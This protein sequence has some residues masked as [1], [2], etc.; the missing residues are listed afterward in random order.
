MTKLVKTETL[1]SSKPDWLD[2][3]IS[4]FREAEALISTAGQK[5]AS[6]HWK[7]SGAE[8]VAVV[9]GACPYLPC[10]L[11]DVLALA[12]HS[13]LLQNIPEVKLFLKEEDQLKDLG[14]LV[15]YT[16]KWLSL[17]TMDMDSIATYFDPTLV[18]KVKRFMSDV[19]TH[20]S[21]IAS[22]SMKAKNCQYGG[23]V[24]ARDWD[25]EIVTH[26]L[27]DSVATKLCCHCHWFQLRLNSSESKPNLNRPLL[28]AVDAWAMTDV[29]WMF[30]G[31]DDVDSDCTTLV[32][33]RQKAF[34]TSI[35]LMAG[36]RTSCHPNLLRCTKPLRTEL[37]PSAYRLSIPSR[38]CI[39][40][41]WIRA[42]GI[43]GCW[44]GSTGCL[45]KI[46]AAAF[47]CISCLHLSLVTGQDV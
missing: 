38:M 39:R 11:Q 47:I 5:W 32:D 8:E 18:N 34:S 15:K 12:K 26:R 28:P 14:W 16:K 37:G 6:Q 33:W 46:Y 20:F 31:A 10:Q 4:V 27:H 23:Q 40:A 35:S 45:Y 24:Q 7:D 3:A 21:D 29:Q 9:L 19:E 22:T 44:V 36:R 1:V 41:I 25:A 17:K 43:G 13:S 2:A 42:A 30:T